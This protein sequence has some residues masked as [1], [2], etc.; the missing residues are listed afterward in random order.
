MKHSKTTN[1]EGVD[2]EDSIE[3]KSD[4]D[5][6]NES[7]RQSAIEFTAYYRRDEIKD[8]FKE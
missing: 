8:T 7:A 5:S 1:H 6:I 2:E 3:N 4:S